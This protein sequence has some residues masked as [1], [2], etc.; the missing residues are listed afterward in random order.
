ML[1]VRAT[2]ENGTSGLEAGI[3]EMLERMQGRLKAF[4]TLREW[5][6]EFN[7]YHRKDGLIVKQNDDLLSATRYAMM[8]RRFALTERDTK[9]RRFAIDPLVNLP[10]RDRRD[11]YD[12]MQF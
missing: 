11:G 6:E 4:A 10:I 8:M 3:A 5:F 12:W 9:Q 7:L 1:A 2:F